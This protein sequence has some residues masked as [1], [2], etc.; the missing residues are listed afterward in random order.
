MIN[1]E[2]TFSDEITSD[3]EK[4]MLKTWIDDLNVSFNLADVYV[5]ML[6]D[7]WVYYG[8]EKHDYKLTVDSEKF[9]IERVDKPENL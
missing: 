3:Y 5:M 8:Y 9:F 7:L 6:P 2:L 1:F 4:N